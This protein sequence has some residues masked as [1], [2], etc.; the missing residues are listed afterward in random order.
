MGT[1]GDLR[2]KEEMEHVSNRLGGATAFAAGTC[3]SVVMR[4]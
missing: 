2:R 4:V 3:R 1:T